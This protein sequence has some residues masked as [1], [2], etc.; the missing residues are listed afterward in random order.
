MPRS[1]EDNVI[2]NEVLGRLWGDPDVRE[3]TNSM[4][5]MMPNQISEGELVIDYDHLTSSNTVS[6]AH[7]LPDGRATAP[8]RY[9]NA[10]IH[11]PS[12]GIEVPVM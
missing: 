4:K 1:S 11:P 5:G 6:P 9:I 10:R 2:N 12:T 7:A 8:L 3:L